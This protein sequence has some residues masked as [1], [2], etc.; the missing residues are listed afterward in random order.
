MRR[1]ATVGWVHPG[2]ISTNTDYNEPWG[3]TA[4]VGDFFFVFSKK[5]VFFIDRSTTKL[6]G[7]I[8]FW[9]GWSLV[10]QY[11]L[12]PGQPF[13][14]QA[15]KSPIFHRC[16]YPPKFQTDTKTRWWFQIFFMFIPTWGNDRI[17][18]IF[19]SVPTPTYLYEMGGGKD[20]KGG[21]LAVS[22]EAQDELRR[23]AGQQP[24]AEQQKA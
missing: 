12:G 2:R 7:G 1:L 6:W 21:K 4:N 24:V 9:R 19:F 20:G 5:C 11:F 16:G 10:F 18:P 22:Q 8:D 23:L 3:V 13:T 14:L 17:W 15:E